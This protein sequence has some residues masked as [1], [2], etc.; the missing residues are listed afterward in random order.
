MTAGTTSSTTFR[1]RV[2]NG[3]FTHNHTGGTMTINGVADSVSTMLGGVMRS[4]ITITEY[5]V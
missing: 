2:G 5:A 4:S 1:I 3:A